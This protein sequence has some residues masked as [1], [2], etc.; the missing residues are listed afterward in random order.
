MHCEGDQNNEMI[1]CNDCEYDTTVHVTRSDDHC[2]NPVQT[3]TKNLTVN[4]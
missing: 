1:L 4:T 3:Q 2:I